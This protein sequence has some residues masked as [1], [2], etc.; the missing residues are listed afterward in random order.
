MHIS[1]TA[2][3]VLWQN[4]FMQLS[5]LPLV[6]AAAAEMAVRLELKLMFA[7]RSHCFGYVA[8]RVSG[9]NCLVGC[10]VLLPGHVSPE[11]LPTWCISHV[12]GARFHCLSRSSVDTASTGPVCM[13]SLSD[14]TYNSR[15]ILPVIYR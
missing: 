13:V 7:L 3:A 6:H 8:R 2:T 1:F 15:I 12:P 4:L 11:S 14:K 10:C 5:Q 9:L